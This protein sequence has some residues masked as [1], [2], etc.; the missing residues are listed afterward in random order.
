MMTKIWNGFRAF[1][2]DL[3]LSQRRL[4]SVIS[5]PHFIAWFFFSSSLVSIHFTKYPSGISLGVPFLSLS[6]FVF[7]FLKKKEKKDNHTDGMA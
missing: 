7:F 4:I 5:S 1:T 2:A 3:T 6:P